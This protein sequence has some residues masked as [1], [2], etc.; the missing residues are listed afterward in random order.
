MHVRCGSAIGNEL[1]KQNSMKLNLSVPLH[2]LKALNVVDEYMT[3]VD[4]DKLTH[5][6]VTG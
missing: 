5:G 1:S 4:S 2:I 6:C 3:I